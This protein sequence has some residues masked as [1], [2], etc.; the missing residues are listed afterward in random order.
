MTKVTEIN[1]LAEVEGVESFIFVRRDGK[2]VAE[3]MDNAV[4]M[5]STIVM[6]GLNCESMETLVKEKRYKYLSIERESGK[7]LIILSLGNFFLG[8]IKAQ[9]Y[10]SRE[11]LDATYSF[12]KN[13]M[14][15][16]K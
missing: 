6:S 3:N 7:D 11:I 12:L 1:K 16:K 5:A 10:Q 15:R 4:S 14:G 13:L 8:I 9:E 2:V